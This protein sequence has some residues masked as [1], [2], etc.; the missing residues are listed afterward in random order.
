MLDPGL[1]GAGS[2]GWGRPGHRLLW[3]LSGSSSLGGFGSGSRHGS[4]DRRG[5]RRL[6]FLVLATHVAAVAEDLSLSSCR[7]HSRTASKRSSHSPCPTPPTCA[8]NP[9]FSGLDDRCFVIGRAR[10]DP[11]SSPPPRCLRRA[12]NPGRAPFF[13]TEVFFRQWERK[14]QRRKRKRGRSLGDCVTPLIL[15]PAGSR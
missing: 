7:H 8:L 2:G 11:A 12:G 5:A 9:G 4:P 15:S 10:Q 13:A 3:G 14:D 6:V 1:P